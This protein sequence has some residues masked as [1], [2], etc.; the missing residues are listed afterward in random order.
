[1]YSSINFAARITCDG[2][3]RK[4]DHVSP[5]LEKLQWLNINNRLALQESTRI[6]KELI[7]KHSPGSIRHIF[8]RGEKNNR[9]TRNNDTLHIE[10]RK[11]GTACRAFS[12]TGP[13]SWNNLPTNLKNLKSNMSFRERLS[14][15]LLANQFKTVT[16]ST[17]LSWTTISTFQ[18]RRWISLLSWY[19]GIISKTVGSLTI[20]QHKSQGLLP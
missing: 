17:N 10:Q 5:L 8:S 4:R 6:H 15:H 16:L 11:T 1:M 13:K 14:K 12:I 3:H 2:N 7:G 20:P 19:L 18:L 9:F